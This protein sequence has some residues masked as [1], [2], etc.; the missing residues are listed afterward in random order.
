MV[1]G[2]AVGVLDDF[3]AGESAVAHGAAHDEAAG[4]VD[5]DVAVLLVEEAGGLE[6]G[7]DDLA[8]HGLDDVG[9]GS[10]FSVLRGHDDVVDAH[11]AAVLVL[12]GHLRLAVRAEEVDDAFL[13]HF[14]EAHG[15]LMGPEN[16]SGHERG[17]L[18]AGVAEHHAL[19]AGALIL[20]LFAVHALGDVGGLMVDGGNDG[21]GA[22]VEAHL[23]I[24]VA[25]V[26]DG[27]AHDGRQISVSLRGDFAADEGHAGGHERFAGDV[28]V[29]VLLEQGVED[30]VGNLVG[31]FVGVAFGDGLRGKKVGAFGLHDAFPPWIR[32]KVFRAQPSAEGRNARPKNY[33]IR[34]Y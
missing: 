22:P 23:G 34:L 9:L 1:A 25:D 5:E 16:G 4:S 11:G 32:C 14:G 17:C 7:T 29:G 24:V 20:G 28:R 6:H 27:A 2:A 8:L 21:A 31:D 10:A 30:G 18:V 12:E 13:A 19:V 15:E 26:A 3:A 33:Y